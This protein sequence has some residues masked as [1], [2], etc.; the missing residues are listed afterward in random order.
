MDNNIIMSNASS[1]N[2]QITSSY[3]NVTSASTNLA[4][5]QIFGSGQNI[6][7]TKSILMNGSTGTDRQITT[8]YLNLTDASL[9]TVS[10]VCQIYGSGTG[11]IF[12]NNTNDGYFLFASNN[13]LGT[14]T[15]PLQFSSGTFI[16]GTTSS[17]TYTGAI[18]AT[19]DNTTKIP[20][21]QWVQSVISPLS[22]GRTQTV[23]FTAALTTPVVPT[24]VIGFSVK[25]VGRGGYPG[26]NADTGVSNYSS[27]GTGGGASSIISNGM[28]PIVG[29]V[30]I[31]CVITSIDVTLTI[32]TTVICSCSNGNNGGNA[33]GTS[34]GS[35]GASQLTG[36]SNSLYGSFS[37]LPGAGGVPGIG[38]VPY[39]SITGVPTITLTNQGSPQYQRFTDGE[40]GCAQRYAYVSGNGYPTSSPEPAPAIIYLTYYY[41]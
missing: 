31:R 5:G 2:R 16:I 19:S 6:N 21:T 20:T 4:V 28:I 30:N 36:S 40:R 18:P 17:P 11:A 25:M 9:P 41:I 1:T 15:T 34:G 29:G 22:T 14:Q 33:S 10:N 23:S 13:S 12:D 8:S 3:F 32:G 37:L 39:Q 24:G 27:G 7:V 26:A 35:A 38:N